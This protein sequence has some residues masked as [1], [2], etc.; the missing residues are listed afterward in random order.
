MRFKILAYTFSVPLIWLTLLLVKYYAPNL[1]I[2]Q[3]FSLG[4]LIGL[5]I[6]SFLGRMLFHSKYLTGLTI[7]KNDIELTYLT[8]FGSQRQIILSL[9]TIT[10]V[11]VK[12]KTFYF[13][14]FDSFKLSQH[15][16]HISFSIYNANLNQM[17]EILSQNVSDRRL[18]K[19]E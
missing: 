13:G 15:E 12:K 6:G 14:D 8:S 2:S 16:T 3:F 11:K 4:W 19:N 18:L 10:E 5:L 9:D 7:D 17:I 1:P